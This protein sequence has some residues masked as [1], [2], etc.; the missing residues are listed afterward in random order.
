MALIDFVLQDLWGL[1]RTNINRNSFAAES[2]IA[3]G[4]SVRRVVPGPRSSGH[5]TRHGTTRN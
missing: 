2:R 5:P 4:A 3:G 1:P